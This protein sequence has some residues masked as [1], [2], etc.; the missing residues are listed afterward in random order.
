MIEGGMPASGLLALTLISR[1]TDH[2]PYYRQEAINARSGVHTP[3]TT[4]AAWAG[5]AGAALEPL[6]D[7]RKRFVLGCRVLHADETPVA[8]MD[9]GAGKTRRA[10]VWAYA[11][12]W[13]YPMPGVVYDFCLGRGAQYPVAFLASND[14][15]GHRR[16][17]GTLLTDRYD[18]YDTVLD[19]RVHPDRTAAACVAHARRKFDE[20]AKA[21]RALWP[22]RRS[23]ASGSSTMSRANSAHCLTTSARLGARNWPGRCGTRSRSGSSWSGGSSSTAGRQLWPSTTRSTTGRH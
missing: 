6:Y 21:G 18:A 17:A 11:R 23:G 3:R 1:F 13:H 12:S 10:Y 2:L 5:Q 15:L 20:L 9:P 14:R 4:L 19:E 22:R 16:W 7:A 8:L